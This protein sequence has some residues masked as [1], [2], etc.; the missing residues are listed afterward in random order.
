MG[1]TPTTTAKALSEPGV[2]LAGE[3]P[4]RH[5]HERIFGAANAATLIDLD[6][7]IALYLLVL[8]S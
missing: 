4:L 3:G 7:L 8:N 2:P 6:T 1:L 5:N